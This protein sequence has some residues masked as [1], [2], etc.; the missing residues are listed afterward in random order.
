[1]D[2]C[3]WVISVFIGVEKINFIKDKKKI[4]IIGRIYIF[5]NKKVYR[6]NI[7]KMFNFYKNS[8]MWCNF[9]ENYRVVFLLLGRG[10]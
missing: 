6:L 10:G 8:F 5:L 2:V 4:C 9:N 7:V 1:M 3:D